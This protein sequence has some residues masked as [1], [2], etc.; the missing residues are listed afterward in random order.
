MCRSGTVKTKEPRRRLIFPPTVCVLD[1]PPTFH[2]TDRH[3]D[4]PRKLWWSVQSRR[5]RR[6][7]SPEAMKIRNRL[8]GSSAWCKAMFWGGSCGPQETAR[9]TGT[10]WAH[11]SLVSLHWLLPDSYKWGCLPVLTRIKKHKYTN[12]SLSL[13][14]CGTRTPPQ[15][16]SLA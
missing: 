10:L 6:N 9:V 5:D 1:F 16:I 7:E 8:G 2:T 3:L 15:S 11:P 14:V 12:L 13:L 4:Q